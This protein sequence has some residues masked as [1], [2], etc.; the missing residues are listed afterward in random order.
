MS[1]VRTFSLGEVLDEADRAA[2]NPRAGELI[3]L[4]GVR[5][6]GEGAHA[7][8]IVLDTEV[9]AAVL[10]Q[11][12][13][14]DFIYNRMWATRGSFAVVPPQLDGAYATNEYPI[15]KAGPDLYLPYLRLLAASPEFM[16]EVAAASVGSTERARLH[17]E[18]FKQIEV[19]LPLVDEQ[20]RIVHVVETL[21]RESRASEA[22]AVAAWDVLR[23]A[24]VKYWE[25]T[26]ADAPTEPLSEITRVQTGGTPDR[27]NPDYF[28]GDI[29]WVKTGEVA[30][31]TIFE[32]AEHLTE[33]GLANCNAKLLPAGS[34]VVAMYGQGATRGRVAILGR[35]MAT[36]QACAAIL[37]CE[38]LHPRYLLHWFWYRYEALREE[39]D[40][41]SQ[42]NLSKGLIASLEIPLVEDQKAVVQRFDALMTAALTEQTA[43]ECARD[44]ATATRNELLAGTRRLTPAS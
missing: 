39:G 40:G 2:P 17:P 5:W 1:T 34:V 42:R 37:P 11:V 19:E 18:A 16:E 21:E 43:A 14:G 20:K 28:N 3:T 25:E 4:V 13:T 27:G 44:L 15:F 30:Y 41:T 7:A 26:A 6:Y 23:A 10:S 24:R 29:P 38:D 33:A 22:A 35:E 32:A 9:K 31:D 12:A 8:S 36:N